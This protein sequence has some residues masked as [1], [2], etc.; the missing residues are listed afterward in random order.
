VNLIGVHHVSIGVTDLDAGIAFYRLLGMTQMTTRPDFGVDG[1]WL[2]AGTQQVHLIATDKAAPGTQ[3]H[4]ALQVADLDECIA[5][6]D[7]HGISS[8]RLPYY[9]AAGHQA[10]LQ[11]PSGNVI[12]LNQPPAG[13]ALGN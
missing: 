6:L 7:N 13:A 4:F 12:E 10:F 3:N 8:F 2:Q 1:A 5:E 9:E 11:D